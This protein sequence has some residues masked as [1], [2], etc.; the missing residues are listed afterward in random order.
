MGGIC[1]H[2]INRGNRRACVFHTDADYRSFQ[3]LIYRAC[4]RQP[5]RVVGYC[6]M[7]N[8]FHL[9]L[10]PHK[11]GDLS[12]WMQ[13]L[14][15]SHVRAYH[16]C[17]GTDGRVWQGRFKAFPIQADE[18]LLTVLRYVERNALRA[19]LVDKAEKWPW[20]SAAAGRIP[21]D[22]PIELPRDWL[23]ILNEPQSGAELDTVRQSVNR[24]RPLGSKEWQ[25]VTAARLGLEAS[26]RPRG[27]PR[28]L[29]EK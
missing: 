16:R 25:E 8:H 23:T 9:V 6:L 18:H 5:M 28:K 2:V 20:S 22:L 11:D 19:N 21:D 12:R 29:I 10:W 27:R 1:Y 4:E 26:L 3:H 7:P 24:E 14:L 17:Y 15:T 13:W